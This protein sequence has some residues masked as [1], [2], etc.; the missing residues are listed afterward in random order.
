M[1]P[2]PIGPDYGDRP[3]STDLQAIGLGPLHP[4]PCYQTQFLEPAF[5]KF[6]RFLA[7]VA[8]AT[9]LLF[10][11]GAKEDVPRDGMAADLAQRP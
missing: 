1:V 9:F 11:N 5:E 7:G 6:P 10:G 4:A 2:H 8:R 3:G